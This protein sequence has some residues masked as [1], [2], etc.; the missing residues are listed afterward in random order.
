MV[1]INKILKKD[2]ESVKT[3]QNIGLCYGG[4]KDYKKAIIYLE[5][6]LNLSKNDDGKTAYY[7]GVCYYE[8]K[9]KVKGCNYI[10]LA[11]EKNY[12][13]AANIRDKYCK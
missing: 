10:N 4:M 13:N 5:K 11:V 7:L 12:Q 1:K 9:N 6:T 8:L 2:K 3:L